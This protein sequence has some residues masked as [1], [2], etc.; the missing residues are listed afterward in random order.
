MK[1]RI[2]ISRT[3]P[4]SLNFIFLWEDLSKNSMQQKKRKE[5]RK[6]LLSRS[7]KGYTDYSIIYGF[8]LFICIRIPTPQQ[9]VGTSFTHKLWFKWRSLAAL[10]RWKGEF[11]LPKVS[12]FVQCYSNLLG[13]DGWK[14]GKGEQQ[15]SGFEPQEPKW[16][17]TWHF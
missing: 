15:E 4:L 9:R 17:A 11:L 10:A 1:T 8:D 7:K 6:F 5:A 12:L 13:D 2:E 3:K 14:V 16:K